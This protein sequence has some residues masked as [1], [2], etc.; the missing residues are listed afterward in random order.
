MSPFALHLLH[1]AFF[2]GVAAAGF[3]V[4][5]N[6]PPRLLGLCF[7]YGA[8]ALAVRTAGY[9]LAGLSLPT[10]S[11]A[12]A[13]FLSLGNRILEEPDS[14]PGFGAGRSRM[15][16]HGARKPRGQWTHQALWAAQDSSDRRG[17]IGHSSPREHYAGGVH[18][19][20]NRH[21]T[22]N[23][24]SRVPGKPSRRLKRGTPRL[25]FDFRINYS[26]KKRQHCAV[27]QFRS[28]QRCKVTHAG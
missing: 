12:A 3:G 16:P 18:S 13:F 2:G 26:A 6:C 19:C 20:G 17:F 11:F 25:T 21:G 1:Q 8:L 14:P 23:S 24:A 28:L 7:A 10:A 5:F 9:E 22:G 4:L 15:H 27:E